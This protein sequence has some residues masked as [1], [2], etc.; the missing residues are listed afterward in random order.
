MTGDLFDSTWK[1][2]IV[3]LVIIVLF[4]RRSFR[5]QRDRSASQC[6]F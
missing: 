6:A 4:G 1:I 5:P 2:L 3:A